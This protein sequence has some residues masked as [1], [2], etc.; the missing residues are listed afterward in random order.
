MNLTDFTTG[1]PDF[2]MSLSSSSNLALDGEPRLLT[3][4][5]LQPLNGFSG[6]VTLYYI[7]YP[8]Q[9]SISLPVVYFVNWP[10]GNGTTIVSLAGGTASGYLAFD[11]CSSTDSLGYCSGRGA[12]ITPGFYTIVVKGVSGGITHQTPWSV[13]VQYYDFSVQKVTSSYSNGTLTVTANMKNIGNKTPGNYSPTQQAGWVEKASYYLDGILISQVFVC[14][15][16]GDGYCIPGVSYT[17]TWQTSTTFGPHN[18]TVTATE[19][20]YNRTTGQF[21]LGQYFDINPNNQRYDSDFGLFANPGSMSVTSSST[22]TSVIKVQALPDFFGTV[23]VSGSASSG[24][25]LA[26]NT[27]SVSLNSGQNKNVTAII[28]VPSSTSPGSY[29]VAVTGTS[30]TPSIT[31]SLNI[32][33]NV[34]DF[35]LCCSNSFSLPTG[36]A[37]LSTG[38][39]IQSLGGFAGTVSLK[40][41]TT[42]VG[43]TTVSLSPTSVTLSSGQLTSSALKITS[44]SQ[45]GT[46]SFTVTGQSGNLVHSLNY[47]V[48]ISACCTGGGGGSVA[49]GTLITLAD[50]SQVPVQNIKVGD[51]MLGYDTATGTYTVSIVNSI[52]VVDT[53]NMLIIHTSAGTPFRVDANPRQTLWVESTAGTIGWVPVTQVR[54][55]DDL[56]TQNGWVKVTSIDFAPAGQHVMYDIF[57]SAPYFADGYL[58]PIHK[59]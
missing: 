49:E 33:V 53:T 5:T 30:T 45:T 17:P 16:G 7:I 19:A 39:N 25:G 54:A 44:G 52:T 11:P 15:W 6:S 29:T 55:G 34:A 27:T 13:N 2:S 36:G 28:S 46:W 41:S 51:K 42:M 57:A 37:I 12:L 23:S 1:T 31:H 4:V 3:T 22:V 38:V 10:G 8:P 35:S 9:G 21:V 56:W 32:V 20:E 58:D 48:T 43:D 18:V 59:M 14:E 50:G 24:W 47:T 26:F 40:L